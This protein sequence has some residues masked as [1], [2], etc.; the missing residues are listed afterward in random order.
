MLSISD[1][2]GKPHDA[3]EQKQLSEREIQILQYLADG[4]TAKSIAE[5]I[6]ISFHVAQN[7]LKA[8]RATLKL[9][10]AAAMVAYGFRHNLI[11]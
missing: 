8:M 10:T 11:N 3:N 6:G 4:L 5:K 7:T 1:N 9:S 2:A